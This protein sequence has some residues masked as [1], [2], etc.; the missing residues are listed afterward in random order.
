MI[1]MK[2]SL[3]HNLKI[4]WATQKFAAQKLFK[5]LFNVWATSPNG[6]KKTLILPNKKL[7]KLLGAWL[8]CKLDAISSAT[9]PQCHISSI[10][11]I[12]RLVLRAIHGKYGNISVNAQRISHSAHHYMSCEMRPRIL[13]LLFRR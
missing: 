7:S 9:V 3:S 8:L 1:Q 4:N 12:I 6:N 5:L 10:F 2:S 11:Y 13:D